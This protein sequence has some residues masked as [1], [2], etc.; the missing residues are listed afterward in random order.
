MLRNEVKLLVGLLLLIIRMAGEVDKEKIVSFIKN[1]YDKNKETP[2]MKV[3]SEKCGINSRVFYELFKS[4]KEAF[5]NAGVPY[6]D[7][8]RKKVEPANVARRAPPIK[9]T[10]E[11]T[12]IYWIDK[13]Q[14]D[15]YSSQNIS[16][17]FGD[18]R[19]KI[20]IMKNRFL[21]SSPQD[22]TDIEEAYGAAKRL[23]N[24]ISF[25]Y[26]LLE[27]EHQRCK[28]LKNAP[29]NMETI[30]LV[31]KGFDFDDIDGSYQKLKEKIFYEKRLYHEPAYNLKAK[32]YY[33][34]L[35]DS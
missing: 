3:I 27:H 9:V 13:N 4:Q 19:Y 16:D 10:P 17:P 6:S 25:S 33:N 5:E 23:I 1:Y 22:E 29:G 15:E 32:Y 30:L 28:T 8:N 34:Q 31:E 12:T 14:L 35:L 24:A 11:K 2:S 20:V 7:E 18:I 26:I 21:Q